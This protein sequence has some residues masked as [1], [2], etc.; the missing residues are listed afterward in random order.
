MARG[1]GIVKP[2][3]V[4]VAV[5]L[6]LLGCA[7]RADT[8][9]Q[10]ENPGT[11]VHVSPAF[12]FRPGMRVTVLPFTVTGHPE[13][14]QDFTAADTFGVKLAEAEFV[15]VDSTIFHRHDLELDALIPASNL[16]AI[17]RQLNVELLAVGTINYTYD[18]GSQSLFGKGRHVVESGSVRLVSL[19]TGEVVMIVT[20]P[21]FDGTVSARLGEGLKRA[22]R[23]P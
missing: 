16:A 14:A 18:N 2:L 6:V 7:T 20:A 3:V 9:Q 22:L 13:R 17:R 21:A 23:Q 8:P 10:L 11:R 12:G 15:L 5:A 4:L 1:T 19:L